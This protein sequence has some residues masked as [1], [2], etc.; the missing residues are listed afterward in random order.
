M[1][2]GRLV[3]TGWLWDESQAVAGPSV[4]LAVGGKLRAMEITRHETD[5]PTTFDVRVDGQPTRLQIVVAPE[6]VNW[7]YP[8]RWDVTYGGVRVFS[9]YE[10]PEQA[11][12]GL[13]LLAQ[14]L[15]PR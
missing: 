10:D 4:R 13:L 14:E 8:K 12:T 9:V 2:V 6:T 5:D 11:L 15:R 1:E 7:S 3:K